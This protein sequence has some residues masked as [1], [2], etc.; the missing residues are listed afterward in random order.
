[1]SASTQD[2]E[3]HFERKHR[4]TVFLALSG[5]ED[6]FSRY[7]DEDYSQLDEH[8]M[9]YCAFWKDLGIRWFDHDFQEFHWSGAS[10]PIARL[11]RDCSWSTTYAPAVGAECLS[12]GIHEAVGALLMFDFD[13][14]NAR[15]FRSPWLLG[16]GVFNYS[17]VP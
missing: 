8:E 2:S 4:V 13:Y 16:V 14:P 10:T 17:R 5:D 9:P 12:R 15:D 3:V 6:S 1:V 7:L 11:L